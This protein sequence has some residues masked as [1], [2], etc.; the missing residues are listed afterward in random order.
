MLLGHEPVE[1][2]IYINQ[3]KK[4]ALCANG[5]AIV[6]SQ[7]ANLRHGR[8]NIEFHRSKMLL[9]NASTCIVINL[10]RTLRQIIYYVGYQ[11]ED[12]NDCYPNS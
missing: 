8:Y 12:I 3:I 9:I 4:I 5:G 2:N 7:R 10:G 6:V 1:I 11:P